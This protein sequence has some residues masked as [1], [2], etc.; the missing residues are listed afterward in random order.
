MATQTV[1]RPESDQTLEKKIQR[2][3]ELYATGPEVGKT[4][5]ENLLRELKS[6]SEREPRNPDVKRRPDRQPSGQGLGADR[7]R[8]IRARRSRAAARVAGVAERQLRATRTGLAP[9]TTCVSCF[10]TTTRSCSSPLPTTATGIPTSTTSRRRSPTQLDVLFSAVEGWPGIH[11][12]KVKDWIAKHQIPAEGWYVAHPDLTV[13]DIR[14]LK[15]VG[16]AVDEFLDKIN[17]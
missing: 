17:G 7:H 10:W 2:L 13:R 8:P 9:S 5:L 12:P 3:R 16:K 14:R 4:A 1:T 11:S 15:R 6:A